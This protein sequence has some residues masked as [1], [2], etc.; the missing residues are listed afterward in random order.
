MPTG[1]GKTISSLLF[2]VKHALLH[3]QR[4]IIYVVPFTSVIEQNAEVI[5]KIVSP[6]ETGSFK[7]LIEHHSALSPEKETTQ[8]PATENWDASIV[9]TAVFSFTNLLLQKHLKVENYIKLPT[10]LSFSMKRKHYL[11]IYSTMPQGAS[12]AF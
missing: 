10:Q 12:G 2:A 5:R 9:T 1:G 6:L 8:S 7:V 3:G 11:L 4:R